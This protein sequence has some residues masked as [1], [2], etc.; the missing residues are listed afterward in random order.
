LREKTMID[1]HDL[2]T[3]NMKLTIYQTVLGVIYRAFCRI[4]NRHHAVVAT[5]AFY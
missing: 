3:R 2:L 4:L 5:L 1:H